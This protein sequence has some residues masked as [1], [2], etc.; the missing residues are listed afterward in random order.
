[1]IAPGAKG[2]IRVKY[3]T[4]R[5][6][7]INKS[8]TITSNA[9]NCIITIRIFELRHVFKVHSVNSNNKSQGNKY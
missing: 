7:A 5:P 4:K 2:T 3:D 1:P 9:N 8:V 6:G